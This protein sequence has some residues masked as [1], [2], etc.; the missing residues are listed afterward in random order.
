MTQL[1]EEERQRIYEEEAARREARQELDEDSNKVTVGAIISMIGGAIIALCPSMPWVTLGIIQAN[2]YAKTTDSYYLL[3]LGA[4]AGLL[5]LASLSYKGKATALRVA[6]YGIVV[7]AILAVLLLIYI[8]VPLS[9]NVSGGSAFGASASIGYG[10]W[11]GY[12]GAVIALIG[13][14]QLTPKKKKATK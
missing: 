13:A 5:G 3:A 6:S 14:S 1:T 12:V 8:Y 4:L 7:P 9:E 11:L 10:Y 2:G